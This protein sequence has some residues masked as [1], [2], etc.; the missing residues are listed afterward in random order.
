M[1]HSQR[2]V[3]FIGWLILLVPVGIVFYGGLK[4]VP[5]YLNY[6]RVAKAMN[7]MSEDAKGGDATSMNA[8]RSSL[9]RRFEIEG[10]EHPTL[11]EIEIHRDGDHWLAVVDYEDVTP[12]FG[13]VS[14][15]VQFHKEVEVY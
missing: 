14:I 6:M 2:G 3:T 4:L 15:L 11:K 10:I 13:N 1:R 9:D 7:G 12:L 8:M 5:I